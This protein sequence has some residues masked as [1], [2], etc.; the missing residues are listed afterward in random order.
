MVLTIT[1]VFF[2][3]GLSLIRHKEFRFLLPILPLA[4]ILLGNYL[5]H[6][7]SN[8]GS[9]K[10]VRRFLVVSSLIHPVVA[11]YLGLYHQVLQYHQ[12]YSR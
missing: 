4:H 5:H 9:P 11:L 2:I 8:R 7:E 1:L 6:I 12:Y 3:F 10:Y